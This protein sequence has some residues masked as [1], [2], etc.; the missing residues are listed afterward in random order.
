M[1]CIGVE[2][3]SI[4]SAWASEQNPGDWFAQIS[5]P[6]SQ[7]ITG[8][9]ILETDAGFE[10]VLV[11]EGSLPA[12]SVSTVGNAV[13]LEIADAVLA[14]SEGDRFEEFSP[15]EGVALV[16]VSNTVGGVEIAI[17]G[18][19]APPVVESSSGP[20]GFS[21]SVFPGVA[22]T[23]NTLE[24]SSEDEIQ[25][26]VTATRREE[27]L[28]DIPRSVTIITREDL[29]AQTALSRRNVEDILS[30][31]IPGASPP[32]GRTLGTFNLRGQEVSILID[33][34]PQDTNSNAT[35]S[36]PLAGLDPSTIERI[37]VVR[38]PN[39][40]FGGQAI[41][42]VVNIITRQPAED[43]LV[44]TTE[45]GISSALTNA[46]E[47]QGYTVSQQISGRSG[48]V[49]FTG[50]VTFDFVGQSYDA[51][52]DRVGDA[53]SF[54]NT[55]SLNGLL[56]IGV[57]LSEQ[58]R[59]QL[60]ANYTQSRRV[61]DFVS[62]ESI[63]D[64]PGIQKAR[65]IRR[66]DGTQII[67]A[68]DDTRFDNTNISLS[69]SDENLFGSE[70]L[71]QLYYR[72]YST[73]GGF[74][75]DN[76]LF[77]GTTISFQRGETEQFGTRLQVD[78]PFNEE[79]TLSLLWGLDYSQDRI[80]QNSVFFDTE[81]FDNSGGLIFRQ[82]EE[83]AFI[84]PYDFSDLG[85]FAQMQWEPTDR[86]TLNGG[87]R[88]VNLQ[89]SVDDYQ[90]IS[91]FSEDPPRDIEGGSV[92][93]DGFVFN[94]GTVY[95]FADNVSAFASFGQGFSFPD[96]GRVLRRPPGEIDSFADTIDLNS[97]VRVDNYE[98]GIRGNWNTV[99][100]SL[101]GFFNYSD[102]GFDLL[103]N[104]DG[105]LRNVRAPR[106]VYGVEGTVDWQPASNWRLGSTLSWQEGE[107]D[108]DNDSEFLAFDSFTISPIK[109]TAY[110][111]NQTTTNWRNRLQLLYSGNRSR[112]FDDGNDGAP[113]DAYLTVDLL[114]TLDVGNGEVSLGVRNLFNALY[115]P[116]EAQAVAPFFDPG[117]YAGSG[118]SLSLSYKFTW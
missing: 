107:L 101:A 18:T 21:V 39:A 75:S 82:T 16:Q 84:P 72:S 34:I 19:D 109:A 60:R 116:V 96:L 45:L 69:Y 114:S 81:E 118:T 22:I 76:R 43:E 7:E 112:G 6:T 62:D 48:A 31:L 59:L 12:A 24:E 41:G 10:I 57:N 25:L 54:D 67:G 65:L 115:F 23:D 102:S 78:T 4:R 63:A 14:L 97:P 91:L 89:A 79:E 95:D 80:F 111:E 93:A 87:T 47:G 38:G 30:R 58:E 42:G 9:Q 50:G 105:T 40:I 73:D 56:N 88:Y 33:G 61:S 32:S 55:R 2:A 37:E 17:T 28:D 1:L 64:I 90:A 106:R 117:N 71:G 70:F 5:E 98:L 26:T 29:E 83:A 94:V 27:T 52:G 86:W 51:E 44:H 68:E 92:N 46:N 36:A 85:L 35:F 104:E 20:Q 15:A 100:T 113:I 74:P 66:P 53:F 8:L 13:V 99:Q 11:T 103:F 110:I 108:E 49:D 77:G 3:I